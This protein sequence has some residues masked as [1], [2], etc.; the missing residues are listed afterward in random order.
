MVNKYNPDLSPI[1]ILKMR[2]ELRANESFKKI[3]K[4]DITEPILDEARK[5]YNPLHN[6]ENH[7]V[8]ECYGLTGEGKSISMIS[9]ARTIHP[10]LTVNNI[11]FHNQ[12]VLDA[13]PD[14]KRP[15]FIIRDENID[16]AQFGSGSGRI[17][18][19]L[20]AIT[21]TLRKRSISFI[22]VGT[23]PIGLSTTQYIFRAIDKDRK[24]RLTRFA[25]I[26]PQT[27]NYLG[28]IYINVMKETD[29]LW[30]LYNQRKEEF[31][32]NIINMDFTHGK[33]QY[34][35]IID[36]LLKELNIHIYQ[37]KKERKLYISQR[38]SNLTKAEIEEISTMLEIQLREKNEKEQDETEDDD[39]NQD[40]RDEP[41][42]PNGE[43]S[44]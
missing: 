30:L 19:Q 35:V 1:Q 12:Q 23:A 43:M 6:E 36:A 3:F 38:Y 9:L 37:K 42:P 27:Q 44:A 29:P 14:M 17:K 40:N 15:D 41:R 10:S 25:V 7:C 39:G 16:F 28:A 26:D 21:Q 34:Q 13:L 20:E 4:L 32:Q 24:Q 5:R 2:E 22:F 33:P 8:Y 18:M 31:M 11:F